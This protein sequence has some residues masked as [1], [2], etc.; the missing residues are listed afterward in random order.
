MITVVG[1]AMSTPLM[2]ELEARPD[3]YDTSSLFLITSSGAILSN[4]AATD[5]PI[6]TILR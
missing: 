5:L 6:A 2:D 4:R 3:E 1:D